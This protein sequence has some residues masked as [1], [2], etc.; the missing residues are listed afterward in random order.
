MAVL[1]FTIVPVVILILFP[2]GRIMAR[3]GRKLQAATAEFNGDV[4]EKL[5]EVRQIGRAACRERV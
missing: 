4:R 2:V 1:I 3:L 5:A